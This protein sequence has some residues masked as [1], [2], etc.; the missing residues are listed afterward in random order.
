MGVSMGN[1]ARFM[2]ALRAMSSLA[3]FM[4]IALAGAAAGPSGQAP[5]SAA[6]ALAAAGRPPQA[7]ERS[8]QATGRSFQATQ[9]S[10]P[11]TTWSQ[12]AV[13]TEAAAAAPVVAGGITV[14]P[15][16]AG[17]D[18]AG[19]VEG[20]GGA[21]WY[22]NAGLASIGRITP[23]GKITHYTDPRLTRPFG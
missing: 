3:L 1:I 5:T 18:P 23:A 16:S 12:Q 6:L 13:V 7:T 8:W 17:S 20:S 10:E 22:T 21:L 11:V 19:I 4:V 2:A 15:D 9:R 14:Y